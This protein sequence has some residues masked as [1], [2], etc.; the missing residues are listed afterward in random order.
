[1]PNPLGSKCF[2]W[3]WMLGN[4]SSAGSFGFF[5]VGNQNFQSS[6]SCKRTLQLAH[7][8]LRPRIYVLS[9]KSLGLPFFLP[10]W[11][12]IYSVRP[13]ILQYIPLSNEFALLFELLRGGFYYMQLKLKCF[14]SVD[15]SSKNQCSQNRAGSNWKESK[16]AKL[17]LGRNIFVVQ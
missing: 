12:F 7:V 16:Y 9:L 11:S 6:P 8:M 13:G 15:D 3:A 5:S 4:W 17:E 10:F 14:G 1:M 2:M